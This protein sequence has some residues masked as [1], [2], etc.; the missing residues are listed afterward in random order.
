MKQSNII[1]HAMNDSSAWALVGSNL[2]TVAL[3]VILK[4]GLLE[5]LWIY[6][7]QSV[8]IGIFNVVRIL[9]L[10]EFS[11]TGLTMGDK[12]V[13]ETP[14][15]K[16]SVAGFFAFHY[17]FF[18]FGYMI[19]LFTPMNMGNQDTTAWA[20]ALGTVS[21]LA[22]ILTAG[23][24]FANHL[25]SYR[26][27][28]E[29]DTEKPNLGTLMFFPYARIIPMHLIIMFG[30]TTGSGAL[31]LFLLLKTAADVIMHAVEHAKFRAPDDF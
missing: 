5:I 27:N 8:I 10:K 7:S 26:F 21:P 22:V 29:S 28:K 23:L 15:G 9:S 19:F 12:P 24:F 1:S 16:R 13:P 14:A 3:A 31:V 25:Y 6:W 11:T 30:A 18:H 4:W 17:G 20:S 2:V